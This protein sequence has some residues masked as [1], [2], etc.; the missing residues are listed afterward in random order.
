MNEKT[1]KQIDDMSYESMLAL[2]RNAPAGH[3]MFQGE[4]GQYYKEAMTKKRNDVGADAHVAAS[5]AIGW[6]G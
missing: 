5:K 6:D 1:K 3:P 2:W 4:I